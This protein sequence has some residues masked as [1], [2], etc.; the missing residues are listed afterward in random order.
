VSI[1]NSNGAVDVS[2]SGGT[3][4][5]KNAF[6]NVTV[7]NF[8]GDL[9]VH[10]GN[11]KVEVLNV[12]GTAE[13]NTSFGEVR[14]SDIGGSLSVRANNS[15]IEGS[16]VKGGANVK[17]SFA[18]VDLQ[19]VAGAIEVDNQNGAVDAS[20]T[21]QPGC[22]PIAIHTSFSPIRVH[23]GGSPSYRVT[24][25]TSFAKIHSDFPLT[26]SGSMSS[27]SVNGAIGDGHCELRLTDNN[28]AIEILNSAS[29]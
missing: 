11:G 8:R 27:D 3:G 19:Q 10:N 26:V 4:I 22:Q 23:L 20:S 13:L 1:T 9:T 2:D 7:H 6:A 5:V 17:T 21:A 18:G 25:S 15:H 24:A 12:S 14:F 16:K 28:G 29:H